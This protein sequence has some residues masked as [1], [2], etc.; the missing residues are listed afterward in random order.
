MERHH[1]VLLSTIVCQPY[2]CP[3]CSHDGRQLKLR[4]PIPDLQRQFPRPVAA[5]FAQTPA[6]LRTPARTFCQDSQSFVSFF[7]HTF[8][9]L[10]HLLQHGPTRYDSIKLSAL[11][12]H[13]CTS[14]GEPKE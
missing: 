8:T 5:L 13:S 4:R 3:L 1:H 9:F 7:A 6:A 14:E 11:R 10:H 2:R 12:T